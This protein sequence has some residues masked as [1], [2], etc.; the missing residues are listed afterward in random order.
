VHKILFSTDKIINALNQR[1]EK[2]GSGPFFHRA[3]AHIAGAGKG[4]NRYRKEP[5]EHHRLLQ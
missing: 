4:R 2:S 1:N 3:H 5:G